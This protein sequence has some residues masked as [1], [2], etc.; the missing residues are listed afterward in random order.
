MPADETLSLDA[1]WVLL[2]WTAIAIYA[3]AFIAYALDPARRSAMAVDAKAVAECATRREPFGAERASD[4]V[5][6]RVRPARSLSL[7]RGG[8]RRARQM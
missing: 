8:P 7:S 6:R 4:P 2:I 5:H 1:I 3:L